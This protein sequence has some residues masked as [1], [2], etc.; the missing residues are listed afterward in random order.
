MKNSGHIFLF[1]IIFAAFINQAFGQSTDP[2]FD[3]MK[4]FEYKSPKEIL[5]KYG[6][7]N[8]KTENAYDYED[9]LIG[10]SVVIYPNT[11][12]EI[13]LHFDSFTSEFTMI[14]LREANFQWE[15]PKNIK[16]GMTLNELIK[17]NGKD[18]KIYG[19]ET[20]Y[21]GTISS[22]E[23]GNLEKSGISVMLTPDENSAYYTEKYDQV[24]GDKEFSTT[25]EIIKGLG[26]T[27]MELTLQN[28]K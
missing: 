24:T 27:I 19:F 11:R 12:N 28:K 23:G 3:A 22:W 2:I 10:M 18:F 25:N 4:L 26:L 5:D 17:I 1:A 8:V 15:T 14:T 9:N 21:G 16:V 13:R 7:D 6:K 20:D